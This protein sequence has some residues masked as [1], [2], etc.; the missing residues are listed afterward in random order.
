MGVAGED[1]VAQGSTVVHQPLIEELV[2]EASGV[3]EKLE[4]F[5]HSVSCAHQREYI[6]KTHHPQCDLLV[7]RNQGSIRLE[8]L[9]LFELGTNLVQRLRVVKI[10]LAL[11]DKLHT[12]NSTQKLGATR[13][14]KY[15]V[16]R[17]GLLG[18]EASVARGIRGDG[19]AIPVDGDEDD[20]RDARV[21]VL[22]DAVQGRLYSFRGHC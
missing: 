3:V 12:R 11:L 5:A 9:L 20:A 19:V 10:N 16:Q 4:T 6:V 18:S 22:G 7:F 1:V 13:N 2:P 15:S 8:N 14:P 17:H 21:R